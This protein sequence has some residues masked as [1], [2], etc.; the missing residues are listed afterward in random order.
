[1]ETKAHPLTID[2]R[3][4]SNKDKHLEQREREASELSMRDD[5]EALIQQQ[6]EH[7]WNEY[8]ASGGYYNY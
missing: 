7:E 8:S 3:P 1:V 5:E 4:L 6:R 2:Y